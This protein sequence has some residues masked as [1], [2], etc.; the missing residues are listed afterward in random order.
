MFTPPMPRSSLA[1]GWTLIVPGVLSHGSLTVPVPRPPV[2]AAGRAHDSETASYQYVYNYPV[3]D[4][5]GPVTLEG[6]TY[7]EP[8]VET[9]AR[10]NVRPQPFM[11]CTREHSQPRSA[12][13][14]QPRGG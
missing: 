1:L 7:V 3:A 14:S 12:S 5:A 4:L 11:S 6:H 2:W 9:K 8:Y 13:A 10:T